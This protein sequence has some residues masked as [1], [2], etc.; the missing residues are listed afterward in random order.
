MNLQQYQVQVQRPDL[1]T[2]AEIQIQIR[3]TAISKL[4]NS[5]GG[6]LAEIEDLQLA[7]QGKRWVRF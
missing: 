3:I 1:K 6:L 5:I 2:I 7:A 4:L